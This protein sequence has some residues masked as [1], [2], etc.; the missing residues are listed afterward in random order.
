MNNIKKKE[1]INY[2]HNMIVDLGM[3]TNQHQMVLEMLLE[4]IDEMSSS[5][6]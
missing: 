6:C 3:Q 2:S 1:I 5:Y 4:N